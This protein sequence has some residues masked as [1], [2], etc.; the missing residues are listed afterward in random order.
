[1]S[2][3]AAFIA[4]ALATMATAA[5]GGSDARPIRLELHHDMFS[6][7]SSTS[8]DISCVNSLVVQYIVLQDGEE[9][10]FRGKCTD[11]SGDYGVLQDLLADRDT[12]FWLQDVRARKNVRVEIR[13]YHGFDAG[14][15]SQPLDE[16]D[17]KALVFWGSSDFVNLTK[18]SSTEIDVWFECR[19]NCNCRAIADL[20]VVQCPIDLVPGVCTRPSTKSCRTK[21]CEVRED[22]Y[23]GAIDCNANVCTAPP[24]ALC[25]D[26]A[27]DDACDSG[28]CVHQTYTPPGE[29]APDIDENFCTIQCPP[30]DGTA[31][32]C[33]TD[34]TCK[35]LGDGVFERVGG[36]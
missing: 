4:I 5:C 33:P 26:C 17:P 9:K 22:C 25:R 13:G 8:Y 28:I 29:S 32:P 31:W 6:C 2:R 14:P 21:P 23:D 10:K 16:L 12:R 30:E 18:P 19:P 15:C 24:K 35:R 27:N 1:M 3:W 20:Q 36:G 34:M 11:V 7:R